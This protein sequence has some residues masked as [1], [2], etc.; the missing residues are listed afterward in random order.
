MVSTESNSSLYQL[1][2]IGNVLYVELNNV[3]SKGTVEKVLAETQ[4]LL[5]D[6]KNKPWAAVVDIRNW[7]MPTFEAFDGFQLIYD[8]CAANNQTHEVTLCRFEMQKN[9]ISNVSNYDAE[10]QLYTHNAE[11][12]EQWLLNKGFDFSLK[13]LQQ[14]RDC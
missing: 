11:D 13:E 1:H 4:S 2:L 5:V 3:W 12:A 14:A 7:I 10:N 6:V 9:I 8:W